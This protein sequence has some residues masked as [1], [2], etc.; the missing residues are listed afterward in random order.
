MQN[1][2]PAHTAPTVASR[3]PDTEDFLALVIVYTPTQDFSQENEQGFLAVLSYL[4]L[5]PEDRNELR[6]EAC[7]RSPTISQ[8]FYVWH[9]DF[10]ISVTINSFDT[11]YSLVNRIREWIVRTEIHLGITD[12]PRRLIAIPTDVLIIQDP[13][14]LVENKSQLIQAIAPLYPYPCE[15][16]IL[17]TGC[18][19][20]QLAPYFGHRN[21][22]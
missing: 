4:L 7:R 18:R 5:H 17:P 14:H 11:D 3:A 1:Q 22:L 10:L 16:T 21:G 20:A 15:V 8:D 6:D 12:P 2:N 9:P 13:F 19:I